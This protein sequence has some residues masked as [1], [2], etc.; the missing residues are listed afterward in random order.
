M[1]QFVETCKSHFQQGRPCVGFPD[2]EQESRP[3]LISQ[4]PIPRKVSATCQ[5][6]LDPGTN[7]EVVS[8][9]ECLKLGHT[10]PEVKL[11]KQEDET[12]EDEEYQP[13]EFEQ[14]MVTVEAGEELNAFETL[15]VKEDSPIWDVKPTKRTKRRPKRYEDD[16]VEEDEEVAPPKRRKRHTLWKHKANSSKVEQL[17][18]RC[19]PCD[20][21]FKTRTDYERHKG[22]CLND[23]CPGMG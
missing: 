1:S 13:Y 14:V 15:P 5:K 23:V 19:P 18:V 3:F 6:V 16:D 20:E 4:T 2:S 21:V 11:V 12:A 9:P 8:C 22:R 10:N 7:A 17:N